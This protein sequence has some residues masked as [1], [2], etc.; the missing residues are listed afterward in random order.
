MTQ[1]KTIDPVRWQALPARVAILNSSGTPR[2]YYQVTVPLKI[3]AMCEG[4]PVEEIPRILTI[5]SPAHHLVSAKALDRLFDV[6]PPPLAIN[7]RE[8][9]LQSQFLTGNFRKL[10]FLLTAFE[11]PFTDSASPRRGT[12]QYT[13][14]HIS[15]DIMRHR[16]LAQESAI[17]L[18][19]RHEHPLTSLPGG[20]SGYLKNNSYERLEEIA[21]IL[22][23]FV[24]DLAGF[25]RKNLWA[26]SKV[27]KKFSE[28]SLK[29]MAG[30]LLDIRNSENPQD[31]ELVV[32][33]SSGKESRRFPVEK[34]LD[35]IDLAKESWS[36]LPFAFFRDK[37]WQGV[38][39]R[40]DSLFFT[41]PLARMNHKKAMD[42]ERAEEERCNMVENLGPF[43]HFSVCAAFWALIVETIQ[44]AE[45]MTRLCVREKLTGPFTRQIPKNIGSEGFA[46]LESPQG[47]IYHH[48][49]VDSKGLVKNI[50]I[51]DTSMQNNALRCLIAQ[52]AYE[53]SMTGKDSWEK[54]KNRIEVSLLP[55]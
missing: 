8:A 7:M 21:G 13:F 2:V 49:Q 6:T 39:L 55:F 52:K 19:G 27:M 44:S 46:A 25:F 40:A 4:R 34:A 23:Q 14:S 15:K 33:D 41:G 54:T 11:N 29:P 38:Q 18:G 9:L 31:D 12:S 17:I 16:A 51:L 45:K 30:V 26:S 28:I 37:G 5:L 48:Y 20:V 1:T 22:V 47:I 43:P 42:T 32:T 10:Y 24:G 53:V 3:S 35:N 36:Y 50:R